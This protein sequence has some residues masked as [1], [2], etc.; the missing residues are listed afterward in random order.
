MRDYTLTS[1]F[2]LYNQGQYAHVHEHQASADISACYYFKTEGDDGSFFF[3]PPIPYFTSTLLYNESKKG[4]RIEYTPKNGQ[5][6]LFPSWLKHGLTV[7]K[8]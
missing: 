5:L 2:S 3:E 6:L 1:W 4:G 7:N 8:T